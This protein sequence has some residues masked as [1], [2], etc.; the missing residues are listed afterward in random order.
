MGFK[1]KE[2]SLQTRP[3]IHVHHKQMVQKNGPLLI[4]CGTAQISRLVHSPLTLTDKGT[5]K[6]KHGRSNISGE[7]EEAEGRG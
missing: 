7:R 4:L 1:P 5:D 2:R 3:L 6:N